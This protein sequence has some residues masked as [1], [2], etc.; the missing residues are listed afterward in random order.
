MQGL[1]EQ[2][3]EAAATAWMDIHRAFGELLRAA[4]AGQNPELNLPRAYGLGIHH[5]GCGALIPLR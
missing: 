2:G 3:H 1:L 4:A 5:C